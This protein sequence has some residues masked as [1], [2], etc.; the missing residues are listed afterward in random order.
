[1]RASSYLRKKKFS[2]EGILKS[3]NIKLKNIKSKNIWSESW[4]LINLLIQVL[5]TPINIF[6]VLVGKKRLKHVFKPVTLFWDFICQARA[7]AFLMLANIISFMAMPLLAEHIELLALTPSRML[8]A[9]YTVITYAFLHANIRH[10]LGNMIALLVFGRVVERRIG[11]K[12]VWIYFISM[13]ISGIFYSL[14]HTILHDNTPVIGA[15]GAIF[16][17]IALAMLID[18]LY[19]T[20][21]LIIPM[22]IMLMGWIYIIADITN[23][24]SNTA[25]HIAHYAHLA[26]FF[27]VFFIYFLLNYNE[28]HRL[29]KGLLINI[30]SFIVAIILVATFP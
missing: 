6:L 4:F 10:L 24:L 12:I 1:M 20:Y 19:I 3:R 27:S 8:I 28:R 11:K 16:G 29:K 15:S 30:I 2:K 26:G 13:I 14:V 22:P 18:P 5:L 21:T 9:P 23:L 25:D 7:T 17:L